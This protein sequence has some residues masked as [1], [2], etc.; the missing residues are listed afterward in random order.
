MRNKIIKYIGYALSLAL[1]VALMSFVEAKHNKRV[2]NNIK[3]SVLDYDSLKFVSTDM[4]G[5]LIDVVFDSL[6]YSSINNIDVSEIEKEVK[7]L[8]SVKNVDV[9]IGIEG[10]LE[11][12]V[13]QRKPIARCFTSKLNTYIDEDGNLLPVSKIYTSNVPIIEGNINDSNLRDVYKILVFIR[14]SDV[15]KNQIVN[16]S[17]DKF[18]EYKFRTRKGNTVIEF[19]DIS[20]IDEKFN[21]LIVFYRKT[22]SDFGWNR[23]KKINLE[24]TDQVV[25]TKI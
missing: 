25:C 20:N 24:Y 4:V 12:D 16:I 9:Y 23:Y 8:V 7:K 18:N 10:N 2:I 3:I 21:K 22:V 1:I 17:V 11:V 6:K 13:K 15:L 19:G 14:K 5:A